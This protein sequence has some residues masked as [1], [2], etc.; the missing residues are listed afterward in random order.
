[1]GWDDPSLSSWPPPASRSWTCRRPGVPGPAAG[2]RRWPQERRR[3]CGQRRPGRPVMPGAARG[4]RRGPDHHPAAAGRAARRPGRRAHPH[5]Q[6]APGLLR[7]LVPGGLPTD[8]TAATA[9]A[10]PRRRRPRPRPLPAAGSWPVT[11]RRPAAGR[12]PPR[13]QQGPAPRRAGRSRRHLT[14]IHAWGVVAAK[15]LGQVGDIG[16]FPSQDHFASY[17]ATAP[18]DASSGNQQRHRLN[19]GGNHQLNAAL[20]TSRSAKLATLDPAAAPIWGSS[21][22]QDP[23]EAGRA[24]KR[25]LANLISRRILADQRRPQPAAA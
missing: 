4:R 10:L 17:T 14:P 2:Q 5:P 9:A 16:R 15:L 3:R 11:A 13:R 19:T 1:M 8:L 24:L 23:A 22:R 21:A 18:L 12:R 7:D 25:R 6:P 20:H